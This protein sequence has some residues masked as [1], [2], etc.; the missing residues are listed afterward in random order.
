MVQL[1]GVRNTVWQCLLEM[2]MDPF[3]YIKKND[4]SDNEAIRGTGASAYQLLMAVAIVGLAVTIVIC[5]IRYGLGKKGKSL[6]EAKHRFL[7][8]VL[9]GSCIFGFIFLTGTVMTIINNFV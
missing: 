3:S 6:E 4:V 7:I 9:I 1:A 8:E 5:G 2:D